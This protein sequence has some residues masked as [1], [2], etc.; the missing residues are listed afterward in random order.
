MEPVH[1]SMSCSNCCFLICLQISQETGKV[2]WYSHLEEF[3][4]VCCDPHIKGF[5]VVDEAQVHIFLEFSCFFSDPTDVGNLI[6]GTSGFSKSSLNIWKF[7]VHILLKPTLE[8]FEHYFAIL[9]DECNC[10]VVWTLF[11]YIF[12]ENILRMYLPMSIFKLFK[13]VMYWI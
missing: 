13:Q 7:P 6:S 3:S 12:Y 4:T 5:S 9:W 1:C 11:I 8:N 10:S 2:V